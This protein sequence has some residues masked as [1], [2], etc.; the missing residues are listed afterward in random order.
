MLRSLPT[1]VTDYYS[2]MPII[3]RIPASQCNA[4]KTI[5]ILK[6]PFTQHNIPEVL[7]TDNGP[8]FDNALFTEFAT[9]W[10]FDH[11]TSSPR[12]P[13]SNGQTEAAMK[14]VKGLLT[15]AKCYGK[16]PYLVIL[17]Y[18]S[19]PI[20]AHLCS[21]AEMLYQQALC[22]TVPQY[23][24]NTDP[25][26]NHNAIQSTEYHNQQGCCKKPPFFAHQTISVINDVRNIWLPPSSSTKPIMA[27]TCSKSLVVESTDV[28]ITTF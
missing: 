27:Y 26:A 17:A 4:S 22:T 20:D 13:R 1:V 11:N 15:H 14:T 16:D 5:S 24:R 10:K 3:R 6:E 28:L 19:T 8:Q 18:W 9:D 25:H 21:P 23:I 2:K 7:H 12:N